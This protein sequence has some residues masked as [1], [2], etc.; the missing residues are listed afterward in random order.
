[1]SSMT[2]MPCFSATARIGIHIRRKA[3]Q[4]NRYNR[5]RARRNPRFNLVRVEIKCCGFDVRKHRASAKRA[6][7]AARGNEGKRGNDH[8]VPGLHAAGMQ[9]EF[10]RLCSG[11][12][13][14][15][16]AH[17]ARLGD[18]PLQRIALRPEDELLRRD[19]F[20]DGGA[21]FG[22]NG[23]ELRPQVEHRNHFHGRARRRV[24][25]WFE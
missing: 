23:F 19:Y 6:D 16:V 1:M 10:E 4:V 22:R 9:A 12:E 15:P 3:E 8:F 14:N 13:P 11:G 2:G 21:N 24:H 17:A 7:G 18:F 20:L 25:C 5:A